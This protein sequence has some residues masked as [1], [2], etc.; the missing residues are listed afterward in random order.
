MFLLPGNVLPA[1]VNDSIIIRNSTILGSNN[2]SGDL[3]QNG[4]AMTFRAAFKAVGKN[5]E[6]MSPT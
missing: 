3:Q 4:D 2:V 1:K 6:N 5:S